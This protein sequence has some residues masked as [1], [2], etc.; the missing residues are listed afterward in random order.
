[1]ERLNKKL[2]HRALLVYASP[3]FGT[4]EE[5]Y[6]YTLEGKMIE[7]TSFPKVDS[8]SGHS[9]WYY[10]DAESGIAHSE[11][12]EEKSFSIFELIERFK[13]EYYNVKSE[14]FDENIHILSKSILEVLEE[15][16]EDT[17]VKYCI[18]QMKYI[19]RIYE[20]S[21]Y[22]LD[23]ID[24]KTVTSFLTVTIFCDVFNLDWFVL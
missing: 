19:Q 24:Y 10:R 13:Q 12:E 21:Q 1:M 20:Y 5:L 22:R 15:F 23:K 8:L 7:N 17:Q 11:P 2:H 6:K 18:S 4:Y 16:R 14:R 9:H 3:I